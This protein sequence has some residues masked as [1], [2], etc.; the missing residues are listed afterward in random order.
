MDNNTHGVTPA[1]RR[2]GPTMA[3]SLIMAQAIQEWLDEKYLREHPVTTRIIV[4]TE[5]VTT[6]T[7]VSI[8]TTPLA[9]ARTAAHSDPGD[10]IDG[11][12]RKG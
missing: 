9:P 2:N 3:H 11:K 10:V 4:A 5:T 7:V 8:E 12:F 6:R 1:P